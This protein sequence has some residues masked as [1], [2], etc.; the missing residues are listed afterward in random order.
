MKVNTNSL[1]LFTY[2]LQ[3]TLFASLTARFLTKTAC[4]CLVVTC[5]SIF[6]Q[7]S[8]TTSGTH[9]LSGRLLMFETWN[10]FPR[11]EECEWQ[12]ERYV[13]LFLLP[14]SCYQLLHCHLWWPALAHS[15]SDE[16]RDRISERR[17][18]R[19]TEWDRRTR[20]SV[21][22]PSFASPATT[23]ESNES[24]WSSDATD[25]TGSRIIDSTIRNFG[26][27]NSTSY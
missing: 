26:D 8:V 16:G 2:L 6:A 4:P 10:P 15:V 17:D 3:F 13:R 9:S 20:L 12:A 24:H 14:Y 1:F 19:D 21:F 5:K 7:Q 18:R 11:L 22:S 23:S 27:G 25:R